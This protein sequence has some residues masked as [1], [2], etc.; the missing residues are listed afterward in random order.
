MSVW[1]QPHAI[2]SGHSPA[3][4]PNN[5]LIYH[6]PTITEPSLPKAGDMG[7]GKGARQNRGRERPAQVA[8]VGSQVYRKPGSSSLL[9]SQKAPGDQPA[10][11]G[12]PSMEPFLLGDPHC[13]PISILKGCTSSCVCTRQSAG[14]AKQG[15]TEGE[16]L[17]VVLKVSHDRSTEYYS[18]IIEDY[19]SE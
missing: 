5:Q 2:R 18:C 7:T 15:Q 17:T 16:L 9:W 6:C 13:R 10:H 19:A 14:L 12:P 3:P 4:A 8:T 1:K 11:S